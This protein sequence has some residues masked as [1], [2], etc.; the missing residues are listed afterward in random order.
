[1]NGWR[2]ESILTRNYKKIVIKRQKS[3]MS[4]GNVMKEG[5]R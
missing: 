5:K 4:V 2:I 3:K 1:M